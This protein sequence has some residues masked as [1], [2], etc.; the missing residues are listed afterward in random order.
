MRK[1]I[2]LIFIL[3]LWGDA[4]A[5]YPKTPIGKISPGHS[6]TTYD[7]DFQ[8]FRYE[9]K[10]PYCRRNVSTKLKK[11]IYK[12]YN[13][14]RER[15]YEFTIDHIIPL[16]IGGSNALSNLWPE[17]QDIKATRPNLEYDLYLQLRDSQITQQE[18]I[19]TVLKAKF[20]YK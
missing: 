20:N 12:L 8:E 1:F 11:Y 15:Q 5:W 7:S 9:E 18:A 13:I 10:I 14:P 16:S 4:S 6:C 19:D 2:V 3:L 17:H